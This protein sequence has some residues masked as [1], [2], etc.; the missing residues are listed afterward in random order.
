MHKK[1]IKILKRGRKPSE[2][3]ANN[4]ASEQEIKEDVEKDIGNVVGDWIIQRR[5]N[6]RRERK[7]SGN[8]IRGW[9]L[10]RGRAN[11]SGVVDASVSL[12]ANCG[13]DE[14]PGQKRLAG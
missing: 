14:E 12:Q 10:D 9:A 6:S 4:V 2:P 13:L 11:A 5:E 1:P 3:H 8:A 7:D